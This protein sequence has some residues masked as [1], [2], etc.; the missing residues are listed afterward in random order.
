MLNVP[1]AIKMPTLKMVKMKKKKKVKMVN[2]S[3]IYLPQLS[4]YIYIN[5]KYCVWHRK[6]TMLPVGNCFVFTMSMSYFHNKTKK[7]S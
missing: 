6:I 1:V 4:K 3:Y 2:F 7:D 5:M